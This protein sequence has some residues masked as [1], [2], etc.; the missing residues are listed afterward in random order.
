MRALEARIGKES[1]FPMMACATA[2]VTIFASVT[3]RRAVV[4]PSGK[5]SSAVQIDVDAEAVEVGVHRG[6]LVDGDGGTVAL[7]PSASNPFCTAM[8]VESVI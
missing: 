4:V 1:T 7:G 3:C 2:R 6:L 8:F 5:G